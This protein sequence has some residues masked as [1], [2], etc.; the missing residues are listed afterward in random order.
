MRL[1]LA[2]AIVVIGLLASSIAPANAIF[3]LSKCE[4]A[5]KAIK[6][7]DSIGHELFADFDLVRDRY[8][9]NR[10]L[11]QS[12]S[13]EISRLAIY[14]ADSAINS[15][16]ITTKNSKCFNARQNARFRKEL[17]ASKILKSSFN[18]L[19]NTYSQNP[20]AEIEI[21][22]IAFEFFKKSMQSQYSV[23]FSK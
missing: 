17:E 20:A 3:G 19:I 13:R 8:I 18:S 15:Y 2:S 4:K 22:S 14:V 7:E 1:K 11:T 23:D 12:Q 10:S 21:N 9:A 5:V 6:N 16:T